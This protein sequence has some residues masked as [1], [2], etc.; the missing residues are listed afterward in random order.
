MP[1]KS[2]MA[3]HEYETVSYCPLFRSYNGSKKITVSQ[4]SCEGHVY[5]YIL[6][7]DQKSKMASLYA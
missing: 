1:L 2:K 3:A 4:W 6:V 5:S 7:A